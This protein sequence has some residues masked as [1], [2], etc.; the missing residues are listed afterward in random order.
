[1]RSRSPLS[2]R[3]LVLLTSCLA[4][5]SGL[6]VAAKAADSASAS[7]TPG[8][9][10]DSTP[11][12]SGQ[13]TLSGNASIETVEVSALR[14]ETSLDLNQQSTAGS[15]LD[16]TPLQTPASVN[17]VDGDLIR[18]LGIPTIQQAKTQAPGITSF[19]YP[20][21]GGNSFA[22]R[23]FYGDN[24]V[25]QLYDGIEIYNAG[26][27]LT[28]PF[29]PWNVDRIETLSGPASVLYGAGAIGG[30]INVVPKRPNSTAQ[31]DAFEFSAGSFNTFHEAADVTGPIDDTG[32]SYRADASHFGSEG[33]INNSPSDSTAASAS[34]RY[35]ATP[36][37]YFILSNDYGNQHQSPYEGTPTLN[38][39]PVKALEQINYNVTDV[40][41]NFVDDWTTLVTQ[42]NPSDDISVHNDLYYLTH[43]RRYHDAYGYTYV[44]ATQKVN[45]ADFRDIKAHEWQIGDD[46]YV[47]IDRQLFELPNSVVAGFD[48][49][50]NSYYR[51]DNSS[52][53]SGSYGGKATVGAFADADIL[54]SAGSTL[55]AYPKYQTDVK[56]YGEYLEDRLAI[57]DN[58]AV[59]GGLR[60]DNYD[61]HRFDLIAL[62]AT[63][64]HYDSIGYNAGVVYNPIDGVALYGQYAHAVDPV[65]SFSSITVVQQAFTLSPGSQV[66]FG[67]KASLWDGLF[68]GTF[69]AYQ[70]VKNNLLAPDP[71]NPS[72]S[73]QVG[74]QSSRGLEVSFVVRP[75]EAITVQANGTTLKA[76]Y[77]NFSTTSGGKVLNLDGYQPVDVPDSAGNILA[78]WQVLPDWQLRTAIQ[79]VD[80]RYVDATDTTPLPSFFTASFGV[81]WAVTSNIKLD[82]RL[83]NAFNKTYAVASPLTSQWIL[84]APRSAT[85]TLDIAF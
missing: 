35:D 48:L 61:V 8:V 36:D 49:N 27:T 67:A 52:V 17:I 21:N 54:Y 62:S 79:Y 2:V 39:R 30:A 7:S 81:R 58:V 13:T 60:H 65:S 59:T 68:E 74:S 84:G 42:W 11:V 46:G 55:L 29:D 37:L 43:Q 69:A 12:V 22:N 5:G 9:S 19:S 53:T 32:L 83:D 18:D 50:D 56:Q 28:F 16:L 44:P 4:S 63:K 38:N 82:L 85:G 70:I 72:V 3:A 20:G 41:L 26:S 57:T 66:E 80:K 75:T 40:D 6:A 25:K 78:F 47:K 24:S 71:S 73:V 64:S 1:M 51:Q 14:K 23:G 10:T 45:I 76:K 33:F 15:R 77:D 31:S 34:I